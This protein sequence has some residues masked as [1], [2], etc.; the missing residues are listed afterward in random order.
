MVGVMCV[1]VKARW[2]GRSTYVIAYVEPLNTEV[3]KQRGQMSKEN[4][5]VMAKV[6]FFV[7]SK[8]LGKHG[9]QSFCWQGLV[10]RCLMR[11]KL[12]YGD[13]DKLVSIERLSCS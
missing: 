7:C 2:C 12:C 8:V 4:G 6:L 1:P 11:C 9:R 3:E 5:R 10:V 13:T